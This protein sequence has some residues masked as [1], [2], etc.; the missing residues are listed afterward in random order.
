MSGTFF[1][2]E[3]RALKTETM[4]MGG[5]VE[6]MLARAVEAFLRCDLSQAEEVIARDKEIN[7]LE[8]KIINQAVLLMATHQP[9]ASDLR[10]LVGTLRIAAELERAGDISANL[11]RRVLGL[12][13]A[14]KCGALILEINEMAALA[15][16][17]IS[18]ALDAVA[19][20][21]ADTARQVLIMDDQ[22]DDLH[23]RAR[24]LLLG[25]IEA[26]GKL[27][28]WGLEL[29]DATAHF[30]RLGDHATNL[31]EEVIYMAQGHNV[32]HAHKTVPPEEREPEPHEP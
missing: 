13:G 29:I 4:K 5:L 21:R 23:K 31:A 9:V 11:G 20:N 17:M 18:L 26:D 25:K 15:K 19:R 8:N 6:E 10:R 12:A 7:A 1:E 32:R 27:A 3:L 2:T 24:E 16:S 28:R 14:A 30:E 22:M